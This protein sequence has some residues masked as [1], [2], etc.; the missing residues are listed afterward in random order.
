MGRGESGRLTCRSNGENRSGSLF[1]SSSRT[2]S[3]MGWVLL[4][5]RDD[6]EPNIVRSLM[7]EKIFCC[8]ALL[9]NG[10]SAVG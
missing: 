4:L 10:I 9:I 8:I 6:P 1:L 3:E 7:L 5:K 2:F